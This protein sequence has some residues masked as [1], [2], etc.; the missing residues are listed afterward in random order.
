MTNTTISIKPPN[1]R[2]ASF[3]LI[4]AAPLVQCRFSTKA[5][6]QI[7]ATQ[8]AG[9]TAKSKR[10]R[11]AK[12][13]EALYEAS[14]HRSMEGWAGVP[15][16]AFRNAM[17]SAC[18]V[19]GFAMTK[20]KLAI[21]IEGDG[22]DQHDGAPLVRIIGEP[23]RHESMVRNA[24]GVCDLRVRSMWE[25]WALDLRVRFDAD[26]FTLTDVTNLLMRVGQQVGIGEGRP[27]SKA[28]AGMGW[29]LFDLSGEAA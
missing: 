7:R 24:S 20:A 26:L 2:T 15:A 18:R 9:S 5:Q 10:Q 8:A 27:D 21:F 13:F 17:I 25:K 22:I 4:G 3:R 12:D 28:S 23:R 19:A 29:G 14:I 16:G 11:E 1:M 6:E